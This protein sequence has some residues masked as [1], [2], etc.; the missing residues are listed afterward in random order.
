MNFKGESDLIAPKDAAKISG[1]KYGVINSHIKKGLIKTKKY[2]S[3][4]FISRSELERFAR[5]YK[6]SS[7]NTKSASVPPSKEILSKLGKRLDSIDSN[8]SLLV[9]QSRKSSKETLVL[10]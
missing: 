7:R 10:T 8:L 5:T 3:R 1:I 6:K 9:A 4:H 2:K